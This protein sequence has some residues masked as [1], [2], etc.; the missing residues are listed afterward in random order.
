MVGTSKFT[1]MNFQLQDI[2]GTN[3][4]MGG[5]PFVAVGD[6]RQLPP[7]RDQFV[8]EKSHLD[9]RPSIAPSHWDDNFKIYYLTDKMRNQKDPEFASLTD[10]VG[11]GTFTKEDLNYLKNCVRETETENDNE[12]FRNGKV[13]VNVGGPL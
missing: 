6:F 10:R 11:N 8:F 13:F 5:L 4:F 9:G 12:N 1:K 2:T 3:E 7:V